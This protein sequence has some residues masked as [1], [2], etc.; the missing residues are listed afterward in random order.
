MMEHT[1]FRPSLV[2]DVTRTMAGITVWFC[3]PSFFDVLIL[4][5][6][7]DVHGNLPD[8]DTADHETGL[9]TR[10]VTAN[11]CCRNVQLVLATKVLSVW[12]KVGNN[13]LY[14]D[15]FIDIIT[16]LGLSFVANTAATFLRSSMPG[17]LHLMSC[18]K[19]ANTRP[20][21]HVPTT[22]WWVIPVL[23]HIRTQ[24]KWRSLYNSSIPRHTATRVSFARKPRNGV[25]P[26]SHPHGGRNC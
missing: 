25:P 16:F 21:V 14:V 17:R 4:V 24:L 26:G 23:A 8:K 19:Y 3:M 20:L 9:C 6:N 10:M 5:I 13:A 11:N 2:D 22:H 18:T 12:L 15:R 7:S 1:V